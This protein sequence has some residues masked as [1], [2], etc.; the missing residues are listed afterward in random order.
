MISPSSVRTVMT[1]AAAAAELAQGAAESAGR[2]AGAAKATYVPSTGALPTV[3]GKA[4]QKGI[5]GARRTS[6]GTRA[7][8]S[9]TR[10]STAAGYASSTSSTKASA[11]N[12]PLAFLKDPKL[13]IED[14]LV[15]LLGYLNAKWD[16]EMQ[17]KLDKIKEGEDAKKASGTKSSSKKK[18]GG[19]LGSIGGIVK[20][21]LGPAGIALEAL[22]IP[23]VRS[24]LQKI[25]G[26]VL[27]AG[28]SALGFPQL[29]PLLLKHGSKIVELAA[30]VASSIDEGGGDSTASSSGGKKAMS[31]SERQTLLMEI[32]RIQQK[33]QEMFGLVS[34]ILK[35]NHD[36]R[37]AIIG[38][39][40]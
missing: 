11:K 13:S 10:R 15:K 36:T 22:K 21:A 25:G 26:P 38:N 27:A 20:S 14:K 29:A 24:M 1:L 5:A 33:Q 2:A 30:G 18:K 39:I 23:A 17:D 37:S 8:S 40:R 7:S 19:L 9:R 6:R 16:K 32:Q 34:N 35:S 4:V 12:D 3:V 28:A 31:D